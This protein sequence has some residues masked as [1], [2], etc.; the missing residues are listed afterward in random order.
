ML[1]IV[2]APNPVLSTKAKKINKVDVK[3]KNLIK[4]MVFTLEHTTDP[5]GVGLAAPQVGESLQLFIIKESPK[6]PL[7]VFINPTIVSLSDEKYPVSD[8]EKPK[9]NKLKSKRNNGVKLEGCLSLKDIW[10]I[11]HR[12]SSVELSF[13][14]EKGVKQVKTFS[15]FLATIIQ[16][17]TDHLHGV[18]FPKRVL[19]QK[20]KLYNATHD[21]KGE[22]VFE[23]MDI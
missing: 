17:E 5:E 9:K 18:L 10:G 19:E 12:A 23:E 14:D 7:Y 20:E 13:M 8:D 22:M 3:I 1:D 4:E 21:E 15:G 6:S 11:V 16:H 2:Q